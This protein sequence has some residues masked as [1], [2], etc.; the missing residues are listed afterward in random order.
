VEALGG[1]RGGIP[2]IPGDEKFPAIRENARMISETIRFLMEVTVDGGNL[3]LYGG[4]NWAYYVQFA[5]RPGRSE[6]YG[7]AVGN[8]NLTA[9]RALDAGQIEQLLALGWEPPDNSSSGNHRRT[10]TVVLDNDRALVAGDV[11]R[12]FLDVFK[13]YRGEPLNIELQLTGREQS[14]SNTASRRAMWLATSGA[15]ARR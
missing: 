7:E 6:I 9:A 11:M 3:I 12:T 8:E 1:V 14:G 10:W 2:R 4:I 5:I 15:R 13:H